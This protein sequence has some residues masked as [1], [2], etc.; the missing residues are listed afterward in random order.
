MVEWRLT[1]NS[2][3]TGSNPTWTVCSKL[4]GA[5]MTGLSALSFF[6]LLSELEFSVFRKGNILTFYEGIHCFLLF[7]FSRFFGKWFEI[8]YLENGRWMSLDGWLGA[9]FQFFPVVSR[10][11]TPLWF[12]TFRLAAEI[13]RVQQRQ[14]LSRDGCFSEILSFQ[15]ISNSFL[16]S[17]LRV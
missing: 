12:R 2:L 13:L 10:Q 16:Y 17:F 6:S 14:W 8:H 11:L 3:V 9:L 1:V 5:D 7:L 4:L 15:R